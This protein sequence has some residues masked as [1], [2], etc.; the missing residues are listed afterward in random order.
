MQVPV[1]DDAY[2]LEAAR[3]RKILKLLYNAVR[4]VSTIVGIEEARDLQLCPCERMGVAV[5]G[6]AKGGFDASEGSAMLLSSTAIY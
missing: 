2:H 3:G 6:V 1:A 4:R 5:G